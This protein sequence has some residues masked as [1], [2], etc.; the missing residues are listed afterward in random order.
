M[1]GARKNIFI[2]TLLA[3]SGAVGI[4]LFRPTLPLFTRRM[5][6][7][8][9]QVGA[10]TS[11]F[12]LSRALCAYLCGKFSDRIGRRKLFLPLGFL[13]YIVSCT[14]LFFARSYLD[15]L[16]ISIFQGAISG[17]MWPMAQVVT[18]ESSVRSF[19]TRALSFYFASGNAG[20]SVG[21]A[22]L[23]VAIIFTMLRFNTDENTA[24]RYIF[25]LSGTIFFI[26]F[27]CSLFLS[28]TM[29]REGQVE[30][31][32]KKRTT[33]M[34]GEFYTILL[35]GFFIGIVPGL[36]RSIMVLY[37]NERFLIPTQN[38]AFILMASNITALFSMLIFSYYSDRR[39]TVRAL[40]IVCLLTGISAII[41]PFANGITF[42][43]VLLVISGTGARSFTPISRSSVSELAGERLGQHIGLINTFSNLG[44]VLGPLAGG[45]FY[46]FFAGSGGRVNLNV[47]IL[48]VVGLLILLSLG[49]MLLIA[50]RDQKAVQHGG[51]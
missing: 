2:L 30:R 27:L 5:G 12:M 8:G 24:F 9:F 49:V 39:G 4:S 40:V 11:G 47:S 45:F 31:N 17:M 51:S 33:A 21:N 44:T 34:T 32:R 6:A 42:L 41:I 28:E 1:K 25:L 14:G 18:I 23:G 13:L 38:I 7:T 15:V 37:L 35:I 26:G 46:D 16:V 36:I 50:R 22:L 19:K 3:F 48:S 10:L 20:M 43:V 29:R